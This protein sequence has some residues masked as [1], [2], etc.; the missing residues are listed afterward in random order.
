[1]VSRDQSISPRYT[2]CIL[3]SR[4]GSALPHRVNSQQTNSVD[5]VVYSR[6]HAFHDGNQT[7]RRKNPNTTGIEPSFFPPR[8][9]RRTSTP[10]ARGCICLT[11]IY[12]F[13]ETVGC[14]CS[15]FRG[16]LIPDGDT[17]HCSRYFGAVPLVDRMNVHTM[18]GPRA[19]RF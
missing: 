14:N 19:E 18:C 4:I 2:P 16:F 3:I 1:M 7:L 6:S 15:R 10:P 17:L 12:I 5:Y 13:S 9:G 8:G 11:N